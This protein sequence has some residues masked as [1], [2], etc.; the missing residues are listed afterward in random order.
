[1]TLV[2]RSRLV[3]TRRGIPPSKGYG[4][5]PLANRVAA[6]ASVDSPVLRMDTFK[7]YV[8]YVRS[9]R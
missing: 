2:A 1:M 3:P 4:Q 8:D 6:V 7:R 9:S 5:E